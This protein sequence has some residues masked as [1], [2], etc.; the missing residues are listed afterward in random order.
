VY[1]FCSHAQ[2]LPAQKENIADYDYIRLKVQ[3]NFSAPHA[4]YNSGL[5][6]PAQDSRRSRNRETPLSACCA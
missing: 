3:N 4:A 1:R 5:Q 6:M 2:E